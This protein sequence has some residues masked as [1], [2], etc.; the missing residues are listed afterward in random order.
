ML[1]L[2]VAWDTIVATGFTV[3]LT[4]NTVPEHVP[5]GDVGV[6]LYTAVTADALVLVSVP[7]TVLWPDDDAPPVKPLP[8]GVLHAYVVLLGIVPVGV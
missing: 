7:F 1:Q 2:D 3:T 5:G 6:T 8:V 4:L